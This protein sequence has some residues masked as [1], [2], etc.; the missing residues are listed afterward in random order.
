VHETVGYR[1]IAGQ[2]VDSKRI[3]LSMK[4]SKDFQLNIVIVLQCVI[5]AE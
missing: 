4:L 5:Q 2:I 1:P 3:I